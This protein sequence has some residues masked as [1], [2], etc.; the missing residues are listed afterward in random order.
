MVGS[1]KDPWLLKPTQEFGS[2]NV[3]FSW[4]VCK[5][6]AKEES[7][8]GKD[9]AAVWED[10]EKHVDGWRRKRVAIADTW[11]SSDVCVV[12]RHV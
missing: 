8:D 12:G 10:V 9:F 6:W 1:L 5:H 3:F 2:L 11:M 4:F 7:K